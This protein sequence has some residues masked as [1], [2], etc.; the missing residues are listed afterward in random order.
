MIA[1]TYPDA[2]IAERVCGERG[3]DGMMNCTMD[4]EEDGAHEFINVDVVYM[5]FSPDRH[6]ES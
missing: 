1:N 3:K 2:R 4:E 5:Q 6:A